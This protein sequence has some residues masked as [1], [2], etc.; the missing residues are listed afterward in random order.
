MMIDE[1][2]IHTHLYIY[3]LFQS[4]LLREAIK[5]DSSI[6]YQDSTK[7]FSNVYDASLSGMEVVMN[8]ISNYYDD[9]QQ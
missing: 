6:R 8:V 9:M 4:R 2:Y 7:V 1:Y 5:E 3:K